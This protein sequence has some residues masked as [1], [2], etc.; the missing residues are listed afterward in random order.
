[1][2]YDI[3]TV[4]TIK[5]SLTIQEAELITRALFAEAETLRKRDDAVSANRYERLG[6]EFNELLEMEGS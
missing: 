6:K 1:M 4:V 5:A 3:E 2:E